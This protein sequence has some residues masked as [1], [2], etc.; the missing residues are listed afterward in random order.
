MS[1]RE[2]RMKAGFTQTELSKITGFNKVYISNIECGRISV[3]NI[4]LKNA[5]IIAKAL[6]IS[7]DD[8]VR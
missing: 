7:S 1:L 6:G 8:L 2:F 5:V 4:T 3:E